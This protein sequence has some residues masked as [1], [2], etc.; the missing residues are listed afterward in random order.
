M[1]LFF[2]I[3]FSYNLTSK[4]LA[5]FALIPAGWL[6]FTLFRSRLR[7]LRD[8]TGRFRE[9]H[10]GAGHRWRPIHGF[11]A[12]CLAAILFVPLWRD[13]EGAYYTIEPARTDTLHAAVT[14][15][16]NAVLVQENQRVSAGQALLRMSGSMAASMHSAAAAQTQDARFRTVTA[17][18]HGDSIGGAAARQTASARSAQL[19]G[20]AESSLVIRAPAD[21]VVLTEN[22]SALLDRDVASGQPL[23][24]LADAGP[25]IVR[26]YIPVSALDRIHPGAE[27]ALALPDSFSIV[28]MPLGSFGSDAVTLPAGLIASQEYQGIKLPVFYCA[29]MAL[30]EAAGD[31]LYG[32]S[33]SAKIFGQRRSLAGRFLTTIVS[34]LKA[35][36]W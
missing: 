4:W 1:M 2:V 9:Q 11:F 10:F 8:V 21:G 3:R 17:E 5:E 24:D 6:A 28:R 36:V 32:V 16:V 31:P 15:R 14:G 22:P 34:L 26:V 27:V 35:H 29:R 20:E 33:G 18:L 7:S 25:R 13:R 30:P 23:L 12:V 19:A